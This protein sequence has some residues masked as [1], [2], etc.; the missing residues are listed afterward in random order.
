MSVDEHLDEVLELGSA[1]RA[2]VHTLP[3]TQCSLSAWVIRIGSRELVVS[4]SY[5]QYFGNILFHSST[6]ASSSRNE[7]F[8]TARRAIVADAR[9]RNGE[10]GNVDGDVAASMTPWRSVQFHLGFGS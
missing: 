7:S 6:S 2:P 3:R 10:V 5:C 9:A 8:W 1:L 4:S